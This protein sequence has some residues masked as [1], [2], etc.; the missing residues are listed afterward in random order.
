[1]NLEI[2]ISA[3]TIVL[4]HSTADDVFTEACELAME[5]DPK[6]WI[7]EL[8]LERNIPLRLVIEKGSDGVVADELE[9][10]RARLGNKSLPGR[11]EMLFRHV[12]VLQNRA[13]PKSDPAYFRMSALKEADD[14][15][16]RIVHGSGL[17][18]IDR[19]RSMNVM[20][21]LHEASFVAIR[22]V[23]NAYSIPLNWDNVMTHYSPGNKVTSADA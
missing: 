1:M 8:R 9:L 13:I 4:S 23:M 12:P 5:L 7:S 22:S 2:V 11:A 20:L 6:K 10:F 15:R 14:L 3:A 16:I 18:E 19:T 21:F 17:P